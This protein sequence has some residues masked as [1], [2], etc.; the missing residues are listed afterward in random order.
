MNQLHVDPKKGLVGIDF[1]A[2]EQVF[3][4]NIKTKP[5][6][7]SYFKIMKKNVSDFGIKILIVASIALT[8]V[9]LIFER[10]K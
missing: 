3:G 2:W 7:T 4:S 8:A 5:K 6:R 9:R 10:E 1:P